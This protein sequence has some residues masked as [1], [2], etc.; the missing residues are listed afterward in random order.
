[1]MDMRK[2]KVNESKTIE[3]TPTYNANNI[4]ELR[5]LLA[6][7]RSQ[8]LTVAI[9]RIPT[10]LFAIDEKYQ[11]P[12]R[13][14]RSLRYLID[15]FDDAKLLPVTGVP[16]DEEGLIYLVDGYGRWKAS[17]IVDPIKYEYLNCLVI[18]NAP[19]EPEERRKFEAEQYAFQNIGVARMKPIEKH[20]A[21]ECMDNPIALAIDELMER[22]NFSF[23]YESGNRS[24]NVLGSYTELWD[25][26]KKHGIECGYFIFDILHAAAFD[27]KTN[28]LSV[29]MLRC[30]K[31]IYK[32]YPNNTENAKEFLSKY[33]RKLDPNHLKAE[34]VTNYPLLD[35]KIAC[36]LYLEDLLVEN[37]ELNHVRT[38]D[39]KKVKLLT[40]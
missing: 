14:N 19:T 5:G 10:R 13:T 32:Y 6:S 9:I 23:V 17:Q 40:A 28:G 24:A 22:Y 39:G 38:V 26:I 3:T 7:A 4:G 1:M 21:F 8:G 30:L 33:L 34:A 20:G 37:L 2:V 35:F 15:N 29:Y 36:S 18:L 25:V 27:R 12:I 11:T 31:D 16:H